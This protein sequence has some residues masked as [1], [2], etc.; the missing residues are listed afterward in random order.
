MRKRIPGNIFRIYN[1]FFLLVSEKSGQVESIEHKIKLEGLYF[2]HSSFHGAIRQ[3]LWN[4]KSLK[5]HCKL[6][7]ASRNEMTNVNFSQNREKVVL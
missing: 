7:I 6:S 2:Q 5:V 3:N 1:L 4:S